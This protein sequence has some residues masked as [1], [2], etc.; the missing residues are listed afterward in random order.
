MRIPCIVGVCYR[1][2]NQS[3]LN[4]DIMMDALRTQFDFLCSRTKLPFFLFGDFNDC[5]V[6]WDSEHLESEL[7]KSLV[8]LVDEYNLSQMITEPTRNSNLLDLLITNRSDCISKVAVI[9]AF[10]NLDHSMIT[11]EL[12]A[13]H[14][15]ELAYKRKV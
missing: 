13:Y 3:A 7:G 9:D 10:D 5:C 12:K 8:N 1:P 6:K 14:T 4:R 15:K 11:G 2:P